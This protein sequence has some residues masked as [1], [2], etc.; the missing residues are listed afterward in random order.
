MFLVSLLLQLIN[1]DTKIRKKS[2]VNTFYKIFFKI[3]LPPPPTACT[4]AAASKRTGDPRAA[5]RQLR[6]RAACKKAVQPGGA[7]LSM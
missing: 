4:K 5:C 7:L 3:F 2:K 1:Y 6:G